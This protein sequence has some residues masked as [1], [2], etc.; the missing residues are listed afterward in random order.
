[1][2]GA[3]LSLALYAA[4]ASAG[5]DLGGVL[6]ADTLRPS[7]DSTTTLVTETHELPPS[8]DARAT[9]VGSYKALVGYGPDGEIVDVIRDLAMVH[10]SAGARLGPVRLAAAVPAA[11]ALKGEYFHGVLFAAGDPWFSLKV[12]PWADRPAGLAVDL[13]A[14]VPLQAST[15][16]AGSDGPTAELR[17]LGA[18]E[19]ERW[20]GA[21]NLGVHAAR[22]VP[23]TT[24]GLE[25]PSLGSQALLRAAVGW[26]LS[27][28][29]R[30]EA[31]LVGATALVDRDPQ[32]SPLEVLVGA[33]RADPD[34]RMVRLGVG[35][36]LLPGV[37]AP[38]ARVVLGV[39][40]RPAA[41]PA[42]EAPLEVRPPEPAPPPAEAQGTDAAI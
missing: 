22:A 2:I 3:L 9:L 29:W 41:P 21:L 18:I 10:W 35:A 25:G 14:T 19:R 4:P 6:A 40:R 30:L 5:E 17:L 1:M 39:A 12:S 13:A 26:Q 15:I 32:S 7:V 8:F 34:G 16:W 42:E 36:G 23:L 24:G 37:G 38:A 20:S 31:E 11:V 28:P 27:E 33:V